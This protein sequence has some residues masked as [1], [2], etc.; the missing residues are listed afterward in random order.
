[1]IKGFRFLQCLGDAL[2]LDELPDLTADSGK[3]LQEI[4]IGWPHLAAKE[5]D[6]GDHLEPMQHWKGE[7]PV[8]TLLDGGRRPRK[9]NIT[10]YVADPR[11]LTAGPNPAGQ[12][13]SGS[14]N[15]LPS[16]FL[17][18]GCIDFR[19]VPHS[20]ATNLTGFRIHLPHR[21]HLPADALANGF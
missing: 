8:H 15:Q 11:R 14:K 5:F 20:R 2:T 9:I 17:E 7:G 12:S 19:A 4:V 1:M 10:S 18:L 13:D 16:H 21:S 3:H 6:N